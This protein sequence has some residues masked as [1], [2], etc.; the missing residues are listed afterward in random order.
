MLRIEVSIPFLVK[1]FGA[2]KRRRFFLGNSS[3]DA[4]THRAKIKESI[5]DDAQLVE[6]LGEPVTLVPSEATNIK[7]T[8]RKDLLLAN[9]ILKSRPKPKGEG[10]IHPFAEDRMWEK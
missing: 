4:Y 8:T 3:I 10:F 5:T 1:D 7:I 9:A 2:R 6:S